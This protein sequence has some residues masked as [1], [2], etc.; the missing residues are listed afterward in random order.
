MKNGRKGKELREGARGHLRD[1]GLALLQLRLGVGR[2]LRTDARSSRRVAP[3]ESSGRRRECLNA[4]VVLGRERKRTGRGSRVEGRR[5][6]SEWL[7]RLH[8]ERYLHWQ[9]QHAGRGLRRCGSDT[10]RVQ[11]DRSGRD[12]L[13]FTSTELHVL[14]FLFIDIFFSHIH[15]DHL[16]SQL[17]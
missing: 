15:T 4:L 12:L 17:L 3:G 14:A 8:L 6:C 5:C 1:R 13:T 7:Q 11:Q 10:Q 2:H 9:R 16:T